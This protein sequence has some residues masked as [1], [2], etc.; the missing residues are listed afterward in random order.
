MEPVDMALDVALIVMRNGG[1]TAMADRSLTNVLKG[2]KEEG[3]FA[4]WRLDFVAANSAVEDKSS[5]I[6]QA[7]GPIGVNLHRVSEAVVLGERVA[8]GEVDT[9]ALASEVERIKKLASPHNRWVMMMA[10]ACTAAFF[11]QIA[12]ESWGSLGLAFVAGAVGQLLRS[13][14]QARK[15]AV[16]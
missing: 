14:L 8:R 12:G 6:V 1:S 16:A 10:A 11:S 5:T 13:L 4:L 3:A 15:Y 2:Y 7:V 9:A